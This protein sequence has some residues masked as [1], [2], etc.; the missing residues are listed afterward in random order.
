MFR[1]TLKFHNKVWKVFFSVVRS[2][3]R[4]NGHIIQGSL[5]REES[6]SC[7]EYSRSGG[8]FGN[9]EIWWRELSIKR[10]TALSKCRSNKTTKYWRREGKDKA[11]I[12][13]K[14][15]TRQKIRFQYLK[16]NHS[17]L[18][19][20]SD[21]CHHQRGQRI[22]SRASRNATQFADEGAGAFYVY[23]VAAESHQR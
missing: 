6:D 20:F 4:S 23:S 21:M 9:F 19:K 2:E 8:L 15:S 12:A 5:Q 22:Y 7:V 17:S 13:R 11:T 16:M 10:K 3:H 18:A 1:Y 14:E